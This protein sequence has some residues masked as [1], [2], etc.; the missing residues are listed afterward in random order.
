MSRMLEALKQIEAR[1]LR[2][3]AIASQAHVKDR[4]AVGEPAGPPA[5]IELDRARGAEVLCD[6]DPTGLHP[7]IQEELDRLCASE[8]LV[9]EPVASRLTVHYAISDSLMIE[10]TLAR[11]ESAVASALEAEEPDIYEDMAQYILTQIKPGCPAALL[12]TSPCRYAGQTEMLSCLSE[13]LARHCPGQVFLMDASAIESKSRYGKMPGMG[14][15]WEETLEEAKKRHNLVLID[16]PPLTNSRTAAMIPRCEGVY[17]VIRL[18]YA[19]PYD[20]TEAVRVIRQC[21]GRLLGSIAVG[22]KPSNL[23]A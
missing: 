13:T 16:A 10:E 14:E 12:F 7:I 23:A 1:H 5:G 8:V 11:A 20:V 21:G 22:D 9:E 4:P 3:Q 17:L 15:R 2:P 18:G 6:D 19:T